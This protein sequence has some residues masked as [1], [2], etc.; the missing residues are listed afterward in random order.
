MEPGVSRNIPEFY[1]RD[2]LLVWAGH[3]T[4]IEQ[5]RDR[6][7]EMTIA[8]ACADPDRLEEGPVDLALKRLLC[9]LARREL[10]GLND[11]QHHAPAE[12]ALA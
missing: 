2:V 3:F 11:A 9:R 7:V 6:L 8:L 1:L 10:A 5:V 12:A 4:P